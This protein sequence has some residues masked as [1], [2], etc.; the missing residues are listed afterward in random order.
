MKAFTLTKMLAILALSTVG[1]T[2]AG[3]GAA[4]AAPTTAVVTQS[5]GVVPLSPNGCFTG[6]FCTYNQG[7][8]GGLCEQ[9]NA[10]GNL[11]SACANKND[12]AFN[13]SSYNVKL[14][15]GSGETGAYYL[16]GPGSYLLYMSS[17]QFNACPGGGTD[18]AGYNQ[19]M[20]NNVASIW[21]G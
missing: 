8:G 19:S 11:S 16:L 14:Y 4:S 1:F 18:C 3:A 20:Q 5:S 2:L 9:M 6:N 12:S 21:M 7:N 10:T 17:N 13:N 15:Y